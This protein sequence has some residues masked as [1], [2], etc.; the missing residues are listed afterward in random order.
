MPLDI[1]HGT[2]YRVVNKD[3]TLG[4]ETGAPDGFV[5]VNQAN[6]KIFLADQG[7]WT[8]GGT[9]PNANFTAQNMLDWNAT[10]GDPNE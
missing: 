1:I 7:V 8:D 5:V 2:G 10:T 6:D 4:A 9:F 3:R